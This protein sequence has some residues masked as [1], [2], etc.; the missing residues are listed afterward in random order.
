RGPVR[1][2]GRAVDERA[3]R[4]EVAAERAAAADGE[5]TTVLVNEF[6]TVSEL[7]GIL[8]VP[9]TQIVG[10]AIKNLGLMVT[11][12][13]RLDFDQIDLIA[14]EFGFQAVREEEYQAEA[15]ADVVADEEGDLV[16][17]PPVVTIM[18]HVDHGKTSL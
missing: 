12:N 15:G 6:I 18:G 8:K 2:G 7:A 16:F 17:R 14:T 3:T 10:F 4:E 9:P 5:R 11:I 13:Q 1:R